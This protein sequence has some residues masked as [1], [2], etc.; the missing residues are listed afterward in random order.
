M[1]ANLLEMKKLHEEIKVGVVKDSPVIG[2][3][4]VTKDVDD[5]LRATGVLIVRG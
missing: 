4:G 1:N 3:S 5:K 2:V